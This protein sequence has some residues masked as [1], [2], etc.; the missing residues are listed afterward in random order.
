VALRDG[1]ADVAAGG[2][3]RAVGGG[4]VGADGDH[5]QA[6]G[7]GGEGQGPRGGEAQGCTEVGGLCGGVVGRKDVQRYR[8][9]KGMGVIQEGMNGF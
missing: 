7:G 4:E 3:T 6:A 1:A 5:V 9:G 8:G 2:A